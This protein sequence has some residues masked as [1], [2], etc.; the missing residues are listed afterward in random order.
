MKGVCLAILLGSKI[1]HSPFNC[2][3][4]TANQPPPGAALG[5]S[6]L[7]PLLLNPA[8]AAAAVTAAPAQA[9]WEV[10][11]LLAIARSLWELVELLAGAM[12][13][14]DMLVFATSLFGRRPIGS[15]GGGFAGFGGAAADGRAGERAGSSGSSGSGSGSGSSDGE[16]EEGERADGGLQV[17]REGGMT[18]ITVTASGDPQAVRWPALGGM[19]GASGGFVKLTQRGAE[20]ADDAGASVLQQLRPHGPWEWRAA[21]AVGAVRFVIMPVLT[22]GLVMGA[23]AVGWLPRDGPVLFALMLQGA[24]PP[25]QAL[26]VMMQLT[27]SNKG[28][29]QR[30]PGFGSS[31]GGGSGSGDGDG[32]GGVAA[33][34]ILQLYAV[35]VLP[36]TV[37]A[38]VFASVARA[39]VAGG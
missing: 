38:S 10:A 8:A 5:L 26:V 13:A 4:P 2:H 19:G 29:R 6:P 1:H 18:T 34:L 3:Q 27:K 31:G 28:R 16:E 23:V 11:L 30:G 17:E 35:A 12:L 7:A 21:A 32:L 9:S 39:A 22:V 37:W 25:A 36:M 15:G 14:I 33:R 20:S 24:M